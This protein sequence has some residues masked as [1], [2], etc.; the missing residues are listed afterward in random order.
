M[1]GQGKTRIERND[2]F[3][4]FITDETDQKAPDQTALSLERMRGVQS[5][6]AK[7]IVLL[8]FSTKGKG[9]AIKRTIPDGFA[10]ITHIKAELADDW[11]AAKGTYTPRYQVGEAYYTAEEFVQYVR[12]QMSG[13]G[14]GATLPS[15]TSGTTTQSTGEGGATS[16]SKVPK[17]ESSN[18]Y[19]F[20]EQELAGVIYD[21]A[22]EFQHLS[23]FHP[24]IP[25]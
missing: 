21:L 18:F 23:G 24:T 25:D 13:Q 3:F 10:S 16:Q 6:S 4:W 14:V 7:K 1:Y 20:T 5:D 8:D 17:S 9:E 19:G 15:T 12:G 2:E 22:P 11:G